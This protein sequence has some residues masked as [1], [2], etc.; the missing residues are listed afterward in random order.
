LTLPPGCGAT[1]TGGAFYHWQ[2]IKPFGVTEVLSFRPDPPPAL[3]SRAFTKDYEEVKSVGSVSSVER[4]QDRSDVARFYQAS[5]PTLVFNLVARQVALAEQGTTSQNARALAL[6]NM[7]TNDSLVASFAAK[8][9]YDFWRPETAIRFEDP[10]GNSDI[11]PDPSFVPFVSTPCF[12]SYPSNHA[13][14]SN[15][16]AEILRRIYGEGGHDLT[17]ENPFNPAVSTLQFSY[18]TFNEICDDIDDARIFGGIH[19]RFDQ[20][21]GHDLGRD[22]ATDV[23]KNWLKK[24]N[25]AE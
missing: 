14:G 24:R 13:S 9:Y 19:F 8:Y 18:N 16:A 2:F 22:I 12:P 6:L 4:P 7:A 3:V 25:G 21:A 1:A 20:V 15:A 17:V 11:V 5:S 23:Y 10:Y